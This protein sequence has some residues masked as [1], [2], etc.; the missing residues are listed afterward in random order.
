MIQTLHYTVT[1]DQKIHC[2]GCEERITNALRRLSGIRDVQASAGTQRVVVRFDSG[3][4]TPDQVRAK[5]EGL[6]YR[7]RSDFRSTER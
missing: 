5:L 6:G 2:E 1:G 4:V 3:H 7:A